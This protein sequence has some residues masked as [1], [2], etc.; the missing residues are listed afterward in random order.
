MFL[1]AR[2]PAGFGA[3]SLEHA[4]HSLAVARLAGGVAHEVKNPLN[5]MALQ[6]ALLTDKVGAAGEPLASACANNLASLRNQ[7]GRVNDV[8]RRLVDV[9]DPAPATAFD[10]GALAADI[11]SLF[12][13][14]ARRRR[15]VLACDA[16]AGTVH[17]RGDAGRVARV[18]L[19][20]VWR[21]LA[22]PPEG[23]RLALRAAHTAD[24]AIVELEHAA[25][26]DAA[27]DWIP[28]VAAEA[29]RDLG[30]WFEWRRAGDAE[31]LEL[32]LRRESAA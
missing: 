3:T 20:L 14:E 23:S 16:P 9:S 11:A 25:V 21:A 28:E 18:L 26:T 2:V 8:V 13:H 29:L 27:L 32:R 31:R 7:I 5:A 4:M 24:L 17:A 10:A 1:T 6:I 15:V 22:R 30:G 12:G 19:G